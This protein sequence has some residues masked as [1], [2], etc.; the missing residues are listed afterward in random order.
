MFAWFH[1]EKCAN[2]QY[3]SIG[4]W[5]WKQKW[6]WLL[7]QCWILICLITHMHHPNAIFWAERTRVNANLFRVR[8]WVCSWLKQNERWRRDA[9]HTLCVV[10]TIYTGSIIRV[11]N[12][13]VVIAFTLL[14]VSQV[15]LCFHVGSSVPIDTSLWEQMRKAHMINSGI[16]CVLMAKFT[17]AALP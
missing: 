4:G 16:P 10:Q 17:K 7:M 1:Q 8:K 14:T 11:A 15:A 2:D 12:T 13:G 5:S 3:R 9:V 6:G